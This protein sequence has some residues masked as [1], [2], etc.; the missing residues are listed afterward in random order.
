LGG[1][2]VEDFRNQCNQR[3]DFSYEKVVD[4]HADLSMNHDRPVVAVGVP[5]SAGRRR[6]DWQNNWYNNPSLVVDGHPR[7]E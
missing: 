3:L 7:D 5:L 4:Y 6:M 1:V 2:V